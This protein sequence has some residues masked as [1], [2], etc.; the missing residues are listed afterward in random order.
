MAFSL[1]KFSPRTFILGFCLILLFCSP[2][3]WQV[4]DPIEGE[5]ESTS[6]SQDEI[7]VVSYSSDIQNSQYALNETY[8]I[9]STVVVEST[10]RIDEGFHTTHF[11]GNQNGCNS[12]DTSDPTD[13][14]TIPF[15]ISFTHDSL[16]RFSI[17]VYDSSRSKL[18][19]EIDSS[20]IDTVIAGDNELFG[21]P[22]KLRTMPLIKLPF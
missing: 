5:I 15:I 21:D 2:P 4:Y 3:S 12:W 6:T 14:K 19:F 22:E 10:Y 7:R 1:F 17:L 20:S 8:A 16:E 13:I 9:D 18:A 11:F